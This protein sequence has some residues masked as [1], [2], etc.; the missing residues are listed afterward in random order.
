MYL[1]F[2]DLEPHARYRAMVS[3][4]V[5]RP[6]AWVS[7]CSAD[8]VLNLAPYSFF[9]VASCNPPVLSVTQIR[10]RTMNDKDTLRNL[11]ET[12]DCVVN[13]VSRANMDK[14]NASCAG[15]APEEDEFELC[16]IAQVASQNVSVPGVAAA[17]VRFECRLR[18]VIEVSKEAMGGSIMLLDVLGVYADDS[19]VAQGQI[20]TDELDIVGKMG[21][22][23]YCQTGDV[24]SVTRAS[25]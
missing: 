10:P 20:L 8:G 21:G 5:P 2:A 19:V 25:V 16:D 13:I 24:F 6:I 3:T 7:S 15:Y 12:G 14:M 23:N 11:R 22:D 9:N 1:N 4:V 17:S 18:E